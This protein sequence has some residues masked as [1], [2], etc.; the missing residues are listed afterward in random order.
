MAH[1][2]R[3]VTEDRPTRS[4]LTR[5]ISDERSLYADLVQNSMGERVRLEQERIDWCWADQR[6]RDATLSAASHPE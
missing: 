4:A 3:W 5:L 2:D 1:R 6:L